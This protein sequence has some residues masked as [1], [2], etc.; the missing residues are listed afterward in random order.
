MAG[1]FIQVWTQAGFNMGILYE[2]EKYLLR[3]GVQI[4][5]AFF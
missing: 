4:P 5:E 1:L 2:Q 3:R